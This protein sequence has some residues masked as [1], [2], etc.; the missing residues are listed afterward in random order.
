MKD[1]ELVELL[2][3]AR[4][5]SAAENV[6]FPLL[7]DKIAQRLDLACSEFRG[8]KTEN[9]IAHIGY[10]TGLKDMLNELKRIQVNGNKAQIQLI[11]KKN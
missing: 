7:M 11:D 8:G 1:Q 9:L 6:I 4:M 5:V 10:I 2:N 3:S